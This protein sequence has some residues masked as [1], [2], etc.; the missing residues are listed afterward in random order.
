MK[1]DAK[2]S[3]ERKI[4]KKKE[5]EKLSNK[6]LTIFTI[7]LCFE[8]VLVF[9]SSALKSGGSYRAALEDFIFT[10]YIIG[11]VGFIGLVGASIYIKK[12]KNKP[13]L[14]KT[15]FNWG[16]FSLMVAIGATMLAATTVIP[17]MFKLI[18]LENIGGVI[19]LALVPYTGATAAYILMAAIAVYVTLMFICNDIKAKKIKKSK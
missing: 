14:S 5:I 4:E 2:I 12:K 17:N 10:I 1:K 3:I 8:V 7:A 13:E 9:L 18:G 19:T 11:A 16:I 6:S 15:L